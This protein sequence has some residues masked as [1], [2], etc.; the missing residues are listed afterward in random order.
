MGKPSNL[1]ASSL[2]TSALAAYDLLAEKRIEAIDLR[3]LL[4][5]NFDTVSEKMLPIY[6]E[7]YGIAQFVQN[8]QQTR[9][10]LSRTI[11][12]YRKK[13]TIW[14]MR[15][16]LAAVGYPS[17]TIIE[18]QQGAA[19][20]LYDGQINYDG[21]YQYGGGFWANFAVIIHQNAAPQ[22]GPLVVA[23]LQTLI[24]DF[25]PARCKLI[26]LTFD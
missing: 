12:L 25:K 13:G 18:G 24:N 15:E 9:A 19:V 20:V 26:S 3:L 8:A 22:P 17:V 6:A 2:R 11:A 4:F 10:L 14:A 7:F 1:I 5:S 21:Q 23:S 16:A